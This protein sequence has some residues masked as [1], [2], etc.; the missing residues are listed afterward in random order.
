MFIVIVIASD[1]CIVSMN[2]LDRLIVHTLFPS[3]YFGKKFSTE[4]VNVV[5]KTMVAVNNAKGML[6]VKKIYIDLL[7]E[8][9]VSVVLQKHSYKNRIILE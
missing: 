4:F 8:E 7:L 3:I 9:I 5:Y 1:L 6:I 2:S